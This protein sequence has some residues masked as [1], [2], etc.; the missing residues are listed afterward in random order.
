MCS[1]EK[2]RLIYLLALLVSPNV[3]GFR[4]TIPSCQRARWPWVTGGGRMASAARSSNI[5][6]KA[7]DSAYEG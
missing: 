5:G 2:L 4:V 7:D 6:M 3:L 1:T